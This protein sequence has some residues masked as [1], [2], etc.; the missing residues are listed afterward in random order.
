M[1]VD[2]STWQIYTNTKYGFEIKV[3]SGAKVKESTE[4]SQPKTLYTSFSIPI[5]DAVS[6]MNINDIDTFIDS[7]L[8][9][10]NIYEKL[11]TLNK[12]FEG[13]VPEVHDGFPYTF[14]EQK[15]KIDG[16]PAL[17]VLAYGDAGRTVYVLEHNRI[18]TIFHYKTFITETHPPK[19]VDGIGS[20]FEEILQSFRFLK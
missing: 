12:D 2:I 19:K 15:L 18:F 1:P 10:K 3:P 4:S 9:N 13:Y 14:I 7:P 6:W 16:I 8:H 17:D 5:D 20:E 11:L